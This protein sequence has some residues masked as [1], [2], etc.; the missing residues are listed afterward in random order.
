MESIF[1]TCILNTWY[2]LGRSED[3]PVEKLKGHT[4][5]ERPIVTWRTRAG[6]VVAYDDRCAHKRFPLSKGRLMPDGTLE[7]AY[8][9]MRYDTSGKCVMIPSHPT[10]P[11]SPAAVVNA[12]PVIEQDGVV[13][14]WPGDPE[15]TY[16]RTPPRVPEISDPKFE[17]ITVGPLEIA[18]SSFLLLENV[19]DIT[20][21]YPLHDGNIG[22]LGTSRIPA[23]FSEGERDGHKFVSILR[24]AK[25]YKQSAYYADWFHHELVDRH[26]TQ[27]IMS[28]GCVRV[29]MRSWPAGEEGD[30]EKERS[31]CLYHLIT[32]INAKKFIWRVVLNA[33]IDHMSKG[34]PTVST[35]KRIAAMFPEI[36]EEDRWALELQQPMMEY[37]DRGY[38]EVFLTPD[39]GIRAYRKV[40]AELLRE[41]G[42]LQAAPQSEMAH[43]MAA[44]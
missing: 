20:H 41:E 18:S 13:W 29:A 38:Q 4:V 6:E 35:C 15:K 3:F 27:V 22:D 32:P 43:T 10:G 5:C 40:I 36:A 30:D 37:P 14:L 17:S 9:G 42:Q 8:H 2:A 7:C 26:N 11:I 31:Y 23:E 44:E 19:I 33:P 39:I 34:D 28:P 24:R 16:L 1:E 25:A 21:F 12:F